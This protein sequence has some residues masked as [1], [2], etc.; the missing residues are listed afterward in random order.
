MRT[1]VEKFVNYD[2]VGAP[3]GA[4]PKDSPLE[5]IA[6]RDMVGNGGLSLR[7]IDVMIEVCDKYNQDKYLLFNNN[8]QPIPEDVYFGRCVAKHTKNLP[9][10]KD[11]TFFAMEQIFNE[12]AIGIHKFWVYQSLYLVSQYMALLEKNLHK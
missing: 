10:T 8:L 12:N 6:N 2:Y 7:N 9:N 11:A 4:S 3:W 1:G 5:I